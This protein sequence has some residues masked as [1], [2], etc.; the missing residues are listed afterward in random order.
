MKNLFT[1][2]SEKTMV[3]VSDLTTNIE[4]VTSPIFSSAMELGNKGTTT[5]K[6]GGATFVKRVEATGI[7]IND[8]SS[9]IATDA[10]NILAAGGLSARQAVDDVTNITGSAISETADF[11]SRT[12]STIAIAAFD[13][14]GDGELN[15]E[16]LKIATEKC[17]DFVKVASKEIA[18]S[19]LVKETAAAA[20]IGAAIAIPVPLIGPMVGAAVGASLGAYKHFTKK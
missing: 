10:K 15:Q 3:A 17:V 7:M 14:N 13:Q 9:T 19:S 1:E 5:A 6:Q 2:L 18:S 12:L 16:D 8:V 4:S 11:A 20:A